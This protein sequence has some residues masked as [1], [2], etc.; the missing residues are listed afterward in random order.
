MGVSI[1]LAK[2]IGSYFIIISLFAIFRRETV[3]LALADLQN[4]PT[5]MVV[6]GVITLMIG[7]LLVL[8]HN[9]WVMA[10]PVI[11]TL[12]SWFVLFIGSLRLFFPNIMGKV[13]LLAITFPFALDLGAFI[14]FAIGVFLFYSGFIR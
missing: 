2:M 3:K 7:L 1:F 12:V 11:V 10:W 13:T 9:I 14:H 8:S 5:L 4:Q 6:I